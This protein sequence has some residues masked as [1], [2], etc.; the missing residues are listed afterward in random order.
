M[1]M[2]T[3]KE[4]GGF[5]DEHNILELVQASLVTNRNVI[6]RG[7]TGTGKTY[8]AHCLA[9]ETIPLEEADKMWE[10][11]GV[12]APR[13]FKFSC[14]EEQGYPDIVAQDV[15]IAGE[16]GTESRVRKQI[17][18]Q[19]LEEISDGRPNLLLADEANFL[20]P[21]VSG[22]FH[23]LCDW[24]NGLWVP[25]LNEF[26]VRSDMHWLILC[27]N[28]YEQRIY[29]GTKQMN[30]ALSGRFTTIDVPYMTQSTEEEFLEE[31]FP[32]MSKSVIS[33]LVSFADKTRRVYKQ[34]L[35]SVPITPRNLIQFCEVMENLN[36][37]VDEIQAV[38]LGVFPPDQH[39]Q[40]KGLLSGQSEREVFEQIG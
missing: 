26:V 12:K 34:D 4:F 23:P 22:F 1:G 35:L 30:A 14:H 5:V 13:L 21:S 38:I 16:N 20:S 7:E 6:L 17:L 9:G 2:R 8:L 29:A 39:P 25:E 28:P 37:D 15:L 18:L 40:V 36:L 19:W 10:P 11:F 3:S 32:K 31:R 33:Q 24:Q 27:L